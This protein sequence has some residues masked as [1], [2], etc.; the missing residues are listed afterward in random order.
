MV[1]AVSCFCRTG[2][3]C[4]AN[5]LDR[6]RTPRAL[7][8]GFLHVAIDRRCYVRGSCCLPDLWRRLAENRPAL[9]EDFLYKVRLHNLA[10][11]GICISKERHVER[12]HQK[13]ALSNR[14]LR[15]IALC[16]MTEVRQMC[17]LHRDVAAKFFRKAKA[18]IRAGEPIIT[19]THA[20]CT[21]G[22]VAGFNKCLTEIHT[23][24]SL[25]IVLPDGKTIA[26]IKDARTIDDLA[27]RGN[28][29]C[30]C[31][32]CNHRFDRRARRVHPLHR[33]I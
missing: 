32:I 31:R 13:S 30:K 14:C 9:R 33:T 4:H 23:S 17:S 27:F 16:H 26:D 22:N 8:N 18:L 10:A 15:L 2:L 12:R 11:I 1:C 29:L 20:E 5:S 6:C 3:A 25:I 28:A 7:L 24:V 19:K 21:K